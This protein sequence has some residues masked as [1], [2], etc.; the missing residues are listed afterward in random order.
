MVSTCLNAERHVYAQ[1][2][3][4]DDPTSMI[5]QIPDTAKGMLRPQEAQ[6]LHGN[7]SLNLSCSK[8]PHEGLMPAEHQT[9]RMHGL[10]PAVSADLIDTGAPNVRR[11]ISPV[12]PC[13]FGCSTHTIF[14]QL[15]LHVWAP[16]YANSLDQDV[17]S[18]EPREEE[19]SILCLRFV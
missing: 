4:G 14:S 13:S 2:E 15:S 1:V 5:S 10:H 16:C 8:W 6:K 3:T 11:C 18:L 17:S 19:H 7:V 12:K 9:S